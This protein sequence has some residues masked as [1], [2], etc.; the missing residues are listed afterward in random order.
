MEV[1]VIQKKAEKFISLFLARTLRSIIGVFRTLV[2]QLFASN[3]ATFH[4][5]SG[6]GSI[7]SILDL[8]IV[9][10]GSRR[11]LPA[12]GLFSRVIRMVISGR[13]KGRAS[14]K[15]HQGQATPAME[16]LA[17]LRWAINVGFRRIRFWYFQRDQSQALLQF[18]TM[19][20]NS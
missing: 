18:T 13:P 20:I 14:R 17:R 10:R 8:R 12:S 1:P 6:A 11:R 4:D 3:L 7:R 9:T 5:K 15:M 19:G 2:A 16:M